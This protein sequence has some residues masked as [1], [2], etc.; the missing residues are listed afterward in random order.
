M[1]NRAVYKSDLLLYPYWTASLQLWR[2]YS[3]MGGAEGFSVDVFTYSSLAIGYDTVTL[4]IFKHAV[5]TQT[6]ET[7]EQVKT[8]ANMADNEGSIPETHRAKR[9]SE[10]P[11]VVVSDLHTGT[12]AH[13]HP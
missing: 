6:G 8:L 3:E 5:L 9:E 4:N 10:F 1:E 2:S 7:V 11:E 12:V 13:V